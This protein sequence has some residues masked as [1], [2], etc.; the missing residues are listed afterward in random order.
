M[1]YVRRADVL[2]RISPECQRI[3][4]EDQQQSKR[5]HEQPAE[6]QRQSSVLCRDAGCVQREDGDTEDDEIVN[7]VE[8]DVQC[9]V[10]VAG[11]VTDIVVR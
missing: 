2:M 3:R 5:I 4:R 8:Q 10:A 6:D 9:D 11:N 7:H 1:Y